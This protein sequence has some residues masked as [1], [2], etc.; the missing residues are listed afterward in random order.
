M[1]SPGPLRDTNRKMVNFDQ[2]VYVGTLKIGQLK[3]SSKPILPCDTRPP[4]V[5]KGL[6]RDKNVSQDNPDGSL[7]KM[8]M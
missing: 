8:P 6:V 1:A 3:D 4:G 2:T 7:F 5:A